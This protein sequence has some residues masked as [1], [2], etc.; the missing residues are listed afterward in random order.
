MT[1]YM[2]HGKLHVFRIPWWDQPTYFFLPSPS[3]NMIVF[4]HFSSIN[5]SFTLDSCI[6]KVVRMGQ[7][8]I[9]SDSSRTT[10]RFVFEDFPCF[11]GNRFESFWC[12]SN[13]GT[14]YYFKRLF[15]GWFLCICPSIWV[16]PEA[17]SI[18][19][20][21]FLNRWASRGMA[22]LICNVTIHTIFD[23]LHQCESS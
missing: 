18:Q 20:E 3:S 4:F 16:T 13:L 1:L 10:Y 14:T 8:R 15:H 5:F 11:R 2:V 22:V 12:I 19:L 21:A 23:V 17:S 7:S 6:C 9:S